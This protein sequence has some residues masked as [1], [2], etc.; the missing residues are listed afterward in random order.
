VTPPRSHA[1]RDAGAPPIPAREPL[2]EAPPP[3]PGAAAVFG[4]AVP[5]AQRYAALLAGDGIPRG[6]IGP[7][8]ASRLW[9]RHVLNCALL[10]D[11]T[12][13]GARVV[14]VGTGA[15]LPGIPM[16]IR[17][18]DL[19]IDLVEPMLRRTAFLT[20]VVAELDLSDRVRIVRG[21]AE[22]RAV[23]EAVGDAAW[24]V[25][26]AVA[27]LDRLVAWSFR[28]LAP[29]GSL[30]A[31]KGASAAEEIA[32]HRAALRAQGAGEVTMVRLGESDR[33]QLVEPTWAVVVRR[34]DLGS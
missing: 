9:Q 6:L 34:P 33:Q 24:V 25:A 20:E 32:T 11:L 18:P 31:L 4:A 26:R 19:R 12:P 21:R 17:R 1:A 7:R 2:A 16:A 22:E 27:P 3:P 5:K 15:G 13:I 28:L 8:E 29:G 30:L 10:T 23:R 14:D